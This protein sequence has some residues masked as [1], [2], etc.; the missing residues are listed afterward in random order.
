MKHYNWLYKATTL[1]LLA[2]SLCLVLGIAL[3]NWMV[4]IWCANAWLYTFILRA[5]IRDFNTAAYLEYNK[6]AAQGTKE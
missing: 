6:P 1:N 5:V 2:S 4:A 3:K